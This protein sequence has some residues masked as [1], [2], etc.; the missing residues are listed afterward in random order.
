MPPL[1]HSLDTLRSIPR[2]PAP[3]AAR[4]RAAPPS[5]PPRVVHVEPDASDAWRLDPL[6]QALREGRM[7][8][9]PTDSWPA[10]AVDA[11]LR[12][13]AARLHDA[14]RTPTASRKPLAL[15][16]RGFGDVA[17]WTA[18]F[19][20]PAAGGDGPVSRGKARA[21]RT[22]HTH[23]ARLRAHAPHHRFEH[24]AQ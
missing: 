5:A 7:A 21:A 16:A 15:L 2:G 12:D 13:A 6:I 10:L 22:L 17:E 14:R 24:G 4:G 9:L 20:R 19:P 23:S 18:G 8:I 3:P 1:T 11:R